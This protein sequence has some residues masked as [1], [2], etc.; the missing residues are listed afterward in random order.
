MPAFRVA[1]HL[2]VIAD[3]AAGLFGLP[4]TTVPRVD[5]SF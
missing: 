5:W 3:V 1:K 4:R 2:D